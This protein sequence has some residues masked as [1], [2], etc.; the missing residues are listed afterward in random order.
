MGMLA[1]LGG[2]AI[3]PST[4]TQQELVTPHVLTQHTH[5]YTATTHSQMYIHTQLY[6][7]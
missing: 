7:R 6:S 3:S 4:Y 1:G 5:V 2:Y